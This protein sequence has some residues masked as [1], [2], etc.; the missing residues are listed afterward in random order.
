MIRHIAAAI[1]LAATLDDETDLSAGE[2]A[3]LRELLQRLAQHP[4]PHPAD[5]AASNARSAIASVF[6]V[7]SSCPLR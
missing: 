2:T 5:V 3:L 1:A 6:I 4:A 7:V